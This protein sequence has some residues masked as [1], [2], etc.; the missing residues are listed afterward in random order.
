[1]RDNLFSNI[2]LGQIDSEAIVLDLSSNVLS[3]EVG[4]L[5]SSYSRFSVHEKR[6][7]QKCSE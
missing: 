5:T 4:N 6:S 3:N 7:F 1:M 2:S